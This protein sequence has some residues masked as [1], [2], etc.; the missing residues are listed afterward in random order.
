M[1]T[2]SLHTRTHALTA[3]THARTRVMVVELAGQYAAGTSVLHWNPGVAAD[4]AGFRLYRGTTA[5]F[6]T[7][8]AHFVADVVDTAYADAAGSPFF[9]RLTA[10]DVH[11]NESLAAL[12]QPQGVLGVESPTL[13]LALGHSWPNPARG[14][15]TLPF[16]LPAA[17]HVRIALYGVDGREVR[18]LVDA[19]MNAGRHEL[20]WDARDSRGSPVA[21]GVYFVRLVSGSAALERR[22]TLMR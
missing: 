10:V 20:G 19:P 13:G 21:A 11:G 17:A 12:L 7:D 16:A 1:T 9:Y 15:L 3:H 6:A 5:G 14:S 8:P 18:V 4:H 22:V 2:H